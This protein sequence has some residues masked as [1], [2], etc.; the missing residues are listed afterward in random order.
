MLASRADVYTIRCSCK[1]WPC[2][3]TAPCV[4]RTCWE[5]SQTHIAATLWRR[6]ST[7]RRTPSTAHTPTIRPPGGIPDTRS[8]HPHGS[9]QT[10]SRQRWKLCNARSPTRSAPRQHESPPGYTPDRLFLC[11]KQAM[12]RQKH[13]PRRA[14]STRH[15]VRHTRGS[16]WGSKA[17]MRHFPVLLNPI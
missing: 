14:S 15:S 1:Q 9:D 3:Y 5:E 13:P 17:Q 10:P 12:N 6:R 11:P 2:T 8:T 4:A 16:F 7:G